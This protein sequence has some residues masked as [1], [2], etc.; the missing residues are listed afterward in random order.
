MGLRQEFRFKFGTP[1]EVQK[2]LRGLSDVA[3]VDDRSDFFVFS[4]L[5]G[6]SEFTFDCELT[7]TGLISDRAGEY[8]SFLGLFL[9]N[10]T[11]QFGSVEVEDV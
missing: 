4:Q 8:F 1:D 10:L 7:E 9:E 5:P 2:F 6:Q 11:G 3:T